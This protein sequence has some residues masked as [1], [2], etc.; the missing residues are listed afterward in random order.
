MDDKKSGVEKSQI[1]IVILI[2]FM[3]LMLVAMV[4]YGINREMGLAERPEVHNTIHLTDD[5][6]DWLINHPKLSFSVDNGYPPQNFLDN[7]EIMVGINIDYMNL[8]AERLG[9]SFEY[10]G[11]D[12]DTALKSALDHKV[13]GVINAAIRPERET[14]LNFTDVYTIYRRGFVLSKELVNINKV[15]DLVGYKIAVKK[16][17]AHYKSL[18]ENF[19]EL[20]LVEVS[21][22]DEA[23]VLLESSEVDAI[24]DD[25]IALDELIVEKYY[26]SYSIGLLY[27]EEGSG[28]SR[29]GLRNDD[30]YL[31]PIMNKAIASISYE[32]RNV[33]EEKWIKTDVA[34]K[35]PYFVNLTDYEREW[36]ELH[37]I[38]RV[39]SDS[40]WAPIEFYEDERYQGITPDYL[41]LISQMLGVKFEYVEEKNWLA[42]L[43][44]GKSKEVDLYS[45]VYR[46][47]EREDFLDFT[48]PYLQGGT[49]IYSLRDTVLY[50]QLEDLEGEKVAVVDGYAYESNIKND[51]PKIEIVEVTSN[52]EG[53]HLLV[54]EK[55]EAYI[56][57]IL[58]TTYFLNQNGILD[59]KI[60]GQT[61]FEDEIYFAV[62]DDWDVFVGILNKTMMTIPENELNNIRNRWVN[63]PVE[64][65]R[66]NGVNAYLASFIVLVI[67]VSI[68]WILK[69]YRELNRRKE[70]EAIANELKDE[71]IREQTMN[72]EFI[73]SISHDMRTSLDAIQS[74]STI[75]KKTKL[76]EY[77][78]QYVDKTL[79]TS[80]GLEAMLDQIQDQGSHKNLMIDLEMKGFDLHRVIQSAVDM[81][82][83]NALNK[84]LQIEINVG[85]KVPHYIKGD[86]TRLGQVLSNLLLNAVQYTE[87]GSIKLMVDELEQH[88]S[89]ITLKFKV[90]DSGIGIS[91]K[92]LKGL[93]DVGSDNS[94]EMKMTRGLIISKN[95][96][97]KMGGQI[98]IQSMVGRGSQVDFTAKFGLAEQEKI[99]LDPKSRMK[100]LLASRDEVISKSLFY[101]LSRSGSI[102]K[103]VST[104][105][106]VFKVLEKGNKFDLIIIDYSLFKEGIVKAIEALYKNKYLLVLLSHI[107]DVTIEG[108]NLPDLIKKVIYFPIGSVELRDELLS[109]KDSQ[110]IEGKD[111]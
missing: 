12:W 77:Q 73:S 109:L 29:I 51:Y 45:A 19:G 69:L 16:S 62:R 75:L 83:V 53:I 95:I 46:T 31:L 25:V 93:F 52:K 103:I 70:T 102:V 24:Y 17:S 89:G 79:N 41:K 76:S 107:R 26:R 3:M 1:V 22:L 82:S 105:A 34:S 74:Y 88:R 28:A 60:S 43:E 84:N 27:T 85:D 33:I 11:S 72:N 47:Q 90:I 36:L 108:K 58:T 7:D 98:D 14:Y 30:N 50:N 94:S 40:N 48:D 78:E 67:I 91:S 59:V 4:L 20:I 10:L 101:Q 68:I 97:E 8:I 9:I 81:I 106:E 80:K 66:N 56:D 57:N 92:Q 100:I 37:P 86:G 110:A 111:S 32:D 15:D 54:Q 2:I 42:L 44:L 99:D 38:I 71:A 49:A 104:K 64:D 21:D 61:N 13:D 65:Q 96:I 87:M 6:M 23:F 35:V 63:I 55:V 18:E 5:E 39:G